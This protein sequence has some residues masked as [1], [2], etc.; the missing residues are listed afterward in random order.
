MKSTETYPLRCGL[1]NV[2]RHER[3][4]KGK[5]MVTPEPKQVERAIKLTYVQTMLSA[6]FGAST[7]GMFLIGFAIDLGADNVLL[8]LMSTIP[9]FFVVFQLLA[10]WLVENKI[11]RKKLTVVF[12]LVTPLCWF[13]IAAIPLFGD[14][15]SKWMRF[16]V[17]ISTIAIVT[18]AAQFA[19]NARASWLGELI[20]EERR[21]RFFGYCAMFAGVVGA[22]FAVIEGRFLDIIRSRGLLAYTALFFFG[23]LFGLASA[24][25]NIPQPDCPLP[26]SLRKTDFRSLVANA[27]RNRHFMSLAVVHAVL[28]LGSIAGPFSAAYCL[29][30]VGLTFFQLGLLNSVGTAALLLSSPLWGKVVDKFGC[31]P[32]L[33]VGLLTIAPCAGI[34]FAIPPQ[35]VAHALW[36]LPW[37]NFVAGVGNAA[38]SI[39]IATLMYKTSKPEGRSVQ[40]ALYS[41]FVSLVAAPMPVLGG[42]MVT[43]LQNAGW[44]I[45]LRVTFY[46][47]SIFVFAA[48]LVA[49]MLR[50]AQSVSPQTLAFVHLPGSIMTLFRGSTTRRNAS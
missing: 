42:W 25:L 36:L 22:G 4:L 35:A 32:V 7:G 44:N 2:L 1:V 37:T 40:F 26:G 21:G 14:A 19:G 41:I 23:I 30:D 17:L 27:L 38:V 46:C 10:A 8:G 48:A 13:F 43:A 6:V 34:W 3:R 33:I 31:R 39:S 15:L 45:D 11:S 29:R 49:T 9:A 12:A 20:P 24:V 16:A 5:E 47:S 50:E 18:L 28:A